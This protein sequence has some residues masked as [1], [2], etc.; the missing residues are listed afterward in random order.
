M[1]IITKTESGWKPARR[2]ERRFCSHEP[3]CETFARLINY[4]YFKRNILD[5][6]YADFT[7]EEFYKSSAKAE[8][9]IW[10]FPFIIIFIYSHKGVKTIQNVYI[11]LAN[12]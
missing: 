7:S 12:P 11:L 3:E 1:M 8:T 2:G 6:I 10:P 4:S 5:Y 9:A